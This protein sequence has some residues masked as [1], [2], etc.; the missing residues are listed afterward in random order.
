MSSKLHFSTISFRPLPLP[1]SW[2]SAIRL[3]LQ[4]FHSTISLP[5][6]KLLFRKFLMTSLRVICGLGPPQS[7]I[8]A[9]P[10][11]LKYLQKWSCISLRSCCNAAHGLHQDCTIAQIRSSVTRQTH[12]L[13]AIFILFIAPPFFFAQE[14]HVY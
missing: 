5:H 6:K 14:L 8:L 12:A 1:K 11:D 2:Q 9:T 4:I 7:K 3:R 10:M 13:R